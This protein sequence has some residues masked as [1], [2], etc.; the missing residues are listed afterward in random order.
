MREDS[1]IVTEE[2]V[3]PAGKP[4]ECFWCSAKIGA[5]H[6]S[7]CVCRNRTVVVEIRTRVV[8]RVPES[9]EIDL[10]ENHHSGRIRN[11]A[12][13]NLVDLENL[14]ERNGGCLCDFTDVVFM[15]EATEKDEEKYGVFRRL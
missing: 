1:W 7:S 15:R 2:H 3:P 8:K 5:E 14:A 13:N 6:N 10:I 11:C 4:G 9:W 12:V